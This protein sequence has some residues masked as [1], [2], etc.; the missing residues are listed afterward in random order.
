MCLSLGMRPIFANDSVSI[1]ELR[2]GTH[3][4]LEKCAEPQDGQAAFDLMV[5]DIDAAHADYQRLDLGPSEITRGRIHDSFTLRD[6]G[7]CT[8]TVN[9]SHVSEFPV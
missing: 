1:L 9:S 2:G 4:V 6:P 5:E 3:I 7:G 8:I